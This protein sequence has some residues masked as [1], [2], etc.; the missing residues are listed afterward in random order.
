MSPIQSVED[1]SRT[2]TDLPQA[3]RSSA[4]KMTL[5]PVETLPCDS[6]LADFGL[7][8]PYYNDF[9]QSLKISRCIDRYIDK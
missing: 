2:K 3:R 5:I 6:R 8:K 4:R 9:S 1:L 7:T